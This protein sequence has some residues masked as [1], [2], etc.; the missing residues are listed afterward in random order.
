M[1]N[2]TPSPDTGNGQITALRWISILLGISVVATAL[3]IAQGT[4][5]G[6]STLVTD[7]GYF[8]N[9]IFVLGVLQ[10]GFAFY[11]WQNGILG[12]NQLLLSSL[13][14]VALF[15]QIGLGYMGHRSGIKEA[16]VVH[17]GLG[18]LTMG[19]IT[20]NATL[21]WVRPNKNAITT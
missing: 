20:I 12:R 17:F 11:C 8:G 1:Q 19:L 5:G 6:T 2:S 18:V 10:I 7:H 14:L 9:V 16:T 21:L 3:L 15:A 13:I 4:Y